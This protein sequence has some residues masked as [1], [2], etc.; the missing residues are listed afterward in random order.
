MIVDNSESVRGIV[1]KVLNQIGFTNV[2]EASDGADALSKLAEK[3]YGLI[4][5]DWNLEPMGGRALLKTIRA[6]KRHQ[7]LPFIAMTAKQAINQVVQAKQAGVTSFI[8]KPFDAAAL[9]AKLS[10]IKV[11]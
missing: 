10:E 5:T 11:D 8:Y 1:R 6:D 7:N 4:L 9:R 2:D 3:N